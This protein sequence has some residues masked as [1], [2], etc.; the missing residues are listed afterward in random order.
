MQVAEQKD[1]SVRAAEGEVQRKR[2]QVNG[3]RSAQGNRAGLFGGQPIAQLRSLVDSR[4]DFFD[5]YAAQC[6]A[7]HAAAPVR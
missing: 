7:S 1:D 6:H 5:R 4:A 2:E 3:A